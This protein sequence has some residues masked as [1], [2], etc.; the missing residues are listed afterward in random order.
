MSFRLV[1]KSVWQNPGNYGHRMTRLERAAAWQLGKRLKHQPRTIRLPNDALFVAHPDCVVSSALIYAAWP[2][3]YELQF[4]R[5]QLQPGDVLVDVG[6]NVGHISLLLSDI[7]GAENIFAF[8]PTPISFQ[9][10]VENWKVNR[11]T[12]DNLSQA[13]VGRASGV[14]LVPDTASPDTKNSIASTKGVVP[15]VEVPLVSLDDWRSHWPRRCVGLLKIDVEGY[16]AEVFAGA[17]SLLSQDRP[18][19]IMFESLSRGVDPGIAAMLR[20]AHYE[21]FQLDETGRA[22]FDQT[23]AQNLFALPEENAPALR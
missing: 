1:F 15:R 5:R 14:A 22:E 17:S 9:R 23:T 18:K 7:V 6:A 3:Y 16:E 11:W 2:E 8:E 19:L 10:L 4:I 12:T 13:A 21:I 20:D